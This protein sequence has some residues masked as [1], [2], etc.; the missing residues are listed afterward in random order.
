MSQVASHSG[1][2][3]SRASG[4][5]R[6]GDHWNA[7]TIIALSQSNPLKAVAELVENSIDA[8][9]KTIVITRGKEK[10]QHYLR[11]KDDGEGVRRNVDGEPDFHYVAT[12]VCDSIKRRLKTQGRQG[13]Q[14]EFGI[15][16]LSFWTLGEDLLLT[17]AGED[18]RAWQMHLR[19]GDP[20]YRITPRPALFAEPGTE[21]LIRGILPGIKNFSGEKI[22]WYLASELRDRIRHSGVAIRVVD[23]AARAEF[24]VEPREFEGRLLHELEGALPA[25]SELYAELYL[26]AHAPSNVVS[27]YRSGTRVVENIAGLEAF[28]RM[29]WTNG[30]VQG[31]IDAPYL[32]LTPGTRLGVIHDAALARLT[33]EL[34]P[35]EARLV[36]IIEDQQRAEEERASRDVL[37]SVQ[38]ALKE[39]LLALPAE[40]YDWFDLHRG[41]GKRRPGTAAGGARAGE[42]GVAMEADV[43]GEIPDPQRQFFDYA[44]PLFSV[45]I[46]PTS[47]VVEVGGSRALR[48]MARDRARRRVEEDL[49]FA[50]NRLEGEGVLEPSDGEITTFHAASEPGLTRVEVIASQGDIVC[51]GEAQITVTA[52]L[53]GRTQGGDTT[54]QGLPGYTYH[55]AAGELWRSR[56][57]AERNLVVINNGHRDFVYA[58]R[59]RMLKL[60]YICRLFAKELVLKN[61]VGIAQDQL[62]ERLLELTLYS[63]ENL[64]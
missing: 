23:R 34:L 36:K 2:G 38:G 61:F 24:R 41:E 7:I 47:S 40:E 32:N 14:G 63:E 57:D 58:A 37:R 12:H 45:V 10:G 31:I 35:L 53:L 26:H 42:R 15:G 28:A 8:G 1:T 25:Q 52:S 48:A 5:L 22:Q 3:R 6:I 17:S 46:S 62:L 55:K 4:N 50:W 11:V 60:R 49:K 20:S 59:N 18:G 39:A 30:Y 27:L 54:Y 9:A 16:L 64:R 51:R 13:L 19:K 29:P 43:S 33:D 44:G 56:F 21:V